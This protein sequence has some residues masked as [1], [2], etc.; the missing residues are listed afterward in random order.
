MPV[1]AEPPNPSRSLPLG[2]RISTLKY[3]RFLVGKAPNKYRCAATRF[4]LRRS[5][6]EGSRAE[7]W[8]L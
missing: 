5:A 8:L 2:L 1:S 4:T 6:G 3:P 7:R